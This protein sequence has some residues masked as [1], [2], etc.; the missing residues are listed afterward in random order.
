MNSS[1]DL[2][3]VVIPVYNSEE[4]LK[5]SIESVLNQTCNNLEVIVVND[6]ST[7]NSLQI[8]QQY[9]DKIILLTQ[10]N[11]GI[12]SAL[13]N[14]IKQA[15]GKWIKIFSGDDILKPCAIE[16][17]LEHAKKLS[18]KTII[19][20]NW[21]IIDENNNKLRSFNENNYNDLESFD[22][23]IRLLDGQ[24]INI[25]TAMIPSALFDEGCLMR[26]VEDAVAIDYDFLLRAAI[27]YDYN[28]HLIPDFLVKY[29]IHSNQFSHQHIT[30]SLSFLPR[31]KNEILDKLDEEKCV[32]Y[33][34]AL[35]EYQK[36]KPLQKR[37]MEFGLEVIKHYFPEW[38][39]D[40]LLLF[41][42]N[43]IRR[44]R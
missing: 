41:Y 18:K 25:N 39:T 12:D 11:Q 27:L 42:L 40:Q 33:L 4:F 34:S 6:G 26:Q 28:F 20:S 23:N 38:V 43:K 24:Q 13:N 32:K 16:K 31:I 44:R 2:V 17:L 21:E 8:L 29:R 10:Q 5:E 30:K 36:K 19:Y 3:S 1:E 15:K 37:T 22:F 35:K 7:D 14:G 9:S